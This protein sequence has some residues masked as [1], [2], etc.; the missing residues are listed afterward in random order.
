ML[1]LAMY[2]GTVADRHDKRRI[3]IACQIVQMILAAVIGA[4][5]LTGQIQIWHILVAACLLGISGAFEMPATS[6]LV[7]ELVD[8]DQIA[9]AIA[10]DR[11]I[12]HATRLIGPALGGYLI[13]VLGRASAFFANSLSFIASIAAVLSI[14]PRPRGTDEEEAQ[15]NTGMKAGIDYVRQDKPTMAM[16]ALMAS[17]TL[18]IFPFLAVMMTL[19]A[20]DVVHLDSLYTGYLMGM[21]GIGAVVSSACIPLVPRASRLP[22]MVAA[23]SVIAVAMCGL[24]LAHNFA[25]AA[26]SLMALGV[27]T[28]FN[29][30][31][32]NTVVQERAPGPMRGRVSALAMLSFVGVMPFTS[33]AVS[34]LS[35]RIGLRTGMF[36]GAAG[37]AVCSLL[38]FGGPA[39]RMNNLPAGQTTAVPVSA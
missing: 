11:S 22:W 30:G 17:N 38:I 12:F 7:P 4:L 5:V 16:I 15:R 23:T 8:K 27:G 20:R 9:T 6:A 19:Y 3:I 2:G 34:A 10:V 37:Y 14:L 39:R 13:A 25:Q 26:V 32:A 29:Y 1:V 21:S 28:A 36:V 31:L 33:V 35:D 18:W 24:A